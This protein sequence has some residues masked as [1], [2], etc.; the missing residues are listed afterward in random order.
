MK[1]AV[2]TDDHE[3]TGNTYGAEVQG[4]FI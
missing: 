1:F 4:G 2:L 3:Q